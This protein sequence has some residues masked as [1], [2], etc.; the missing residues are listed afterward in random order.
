MG[1]YQCDRFNAEPELCHERAIK[2]IC[3]Y[4]LATKDNKIIVKVD[5]SRSLECH[6]DADF[7]GG[8]AD[9]NQSNP[10]SVL[11][12]VE[13]STLPWSTIT[14]GILFQMEPLQLNILILQNKQPTF[15]Q[16]HCLK[17]HVFLL[18]RN[19]WDGNYVCQTTYYVIGSLLLLFARE[20]ENTY[21]C[22]LCTVW[23]VRM[24]FWVF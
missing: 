20:C 24:S 18:G 7:A 12:R 11:S 21:S 6:M 9:G 22:Y 13:Y 4:L 17:R 19:W 23:Y 5:V 16:N 15:L 2:R 1:T 10:E 8:L 3:K 14:V